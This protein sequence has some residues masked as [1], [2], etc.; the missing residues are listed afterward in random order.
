VVKYTVG[1][2]LMVDIQEHG[3]GVLTKEGLERF[4]P[5]ML[6]VLC[7]KVAESPSAGYVEADQA[8]ELKRDWAKLVRPPSMDL[9]EQQA[10][11]A[12][13]VKWKRK[14]VSFL[15]AVLPAH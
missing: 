7:G 5:T 3:F 6:A 13:I 15:A 8:W 2:D 14:A 11:E 1:G 9:R 10:L 4:G 12:E